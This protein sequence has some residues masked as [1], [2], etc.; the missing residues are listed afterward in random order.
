[1]RWQIPHRLSQA[2]FADKS[3]VD[4]DLA[5]GEPK[6]AMECQC[7]GATQNSYQTMVATFGAACL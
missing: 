4:D 3:W 1:M 7:G 2:P 5:C 6:Q